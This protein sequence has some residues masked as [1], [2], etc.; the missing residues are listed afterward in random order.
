MPSHTR[1]SLL[2]NLRI[3]MLV[4]LAVSLLSFWAKSHYLRKTE[5]SALELSLKTDSMIWVARQMPE[6]VSGYATLRDQVGVA[7][8]LETLDALALRLGILHRRATILSIPN[9]DGL[10]EI[11]IENIVLRRGYLEKSAQL[12]QMTDAV[13][14]R[15]ETMTWHLETREADVGGMLTRLRENGAD[16]ALPGERVDELLAISKLITSISSLRRLVVNIPHLGLEEAYTTKLQL[17]REVSTISNE[18]TKMRPSARRTA[19]VADVIAFKETMIAQGGVFPLIKQ[20]T[21][22]HSTHLASEAKATEQLDALVAVTEDGTLGVV[23]ELQALA[24]ENRSMTQAMRRVDFFMTIFIWVFGIA[25]FWRLIERNLFLRLER[26]ITRLGA[27]TRG[28]YSR[29]SPPSAADEVGVLETAVETLRITTREL[30]MT[31]AT[32]D[33]ILENAPSGIVTMDSDGLITRV[34]RVM[35]DTLG[36]ARDKL[37][38]QNAEKLLSSITPPEQRLLLPVAIDAPLVRDLAIRHADGRTVHTEIVVRRIEAEAKSGVI[39]VCHDVSERKEAETRLRAAH[40]E[41]QRS[42]KDLDS[43]AYAAS[44]DLKAPL[45]AIEN[46]L[47]WVEE[48]LDGHIA[49]ETAR[50]F[51]MMRGRMNRMKRLLDDLLDYSRIGRDDIGSEIVPGAELVAEIVGLCDIPPGFKVET[52]DGLKALPV[53]VMPLKNVLLNLVSNA[54]KH[55]DRAQGKIRISAEELGD[56]L[57]FEVADDG[58]GIPAEF[59]ERVLRMFETL[60]PRDQ[61]EGSGMGLA[62]VKR[63]VELRGGHLEIRSGAGRGTAFRFIWPRAGVVH[64]RRQA[65]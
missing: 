43:F 64:P 38:G 20:M 62:M 27:M 10:E 28:D 12:A 49:G 4:V 56:L 61:V 33:T 52:S 9:A 1:H 60:K 16:D 47:G 31:H 11:M 50:N 45:R 24:L 15:L 59:H 2:W 35:E 46:M 25:I 34:N 42:N 44:H 63:H 54:V 7:P 41:L 39:A 23:G 17:V 40:A 53:Q 6:L 65:G 3:L 57:L 48:D 14:R 32:L 18:L 13:S 22:A 5:V 29:P 8:S 30:A 58:P 36:V 26:L 19:L 55:H 51:E 37:L 21:Q